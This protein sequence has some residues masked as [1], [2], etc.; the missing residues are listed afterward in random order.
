MLIKGAFLSASLVDMI[1]KKG[2]HGN[3]IAG[4]PISLTAPHSIGV[5]VVPHRKA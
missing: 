1:Q 2:E 3:F 4:H 5:F